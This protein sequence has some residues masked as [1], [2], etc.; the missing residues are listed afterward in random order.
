[1]DDVVVRGSYRRSQFRRELTELVQKHYERENVNPY[2]L[3]EDFEISHKEAE[4]I[5]GFM[6][7]G[8][9]KVSTIFQALA[10]M[11]LRLE[12]SFV[13]DDEKLDFFDRDAG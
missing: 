10:A 4:R 5:L 3:E 1:M 8:P 11:G 7:N 13:K 2:I 9:K 6:D 12:F